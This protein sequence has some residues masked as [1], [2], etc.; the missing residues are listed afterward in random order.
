MEWVVAW[1][2]IPASEDS[3][4]RHDEV[5]PDEYLLVDYLGYATR[6]ALIL[7]SCGVL[8]DYCLFCYFAIN[9]TIRVFWKS[10]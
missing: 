5:Y 2:S 8:L 3:W 1:Q 9:D 10:C 6:G 7:Q 4:P